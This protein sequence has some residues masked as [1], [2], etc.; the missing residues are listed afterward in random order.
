MLLHKL[1]E[2]FSMSNDKI[3]E[4]RKILRQ[5]KTMED[6]KNNLNTTDRAEDV[7]PPPVN[8]TTTEGGA[9]EP[10]PQALPDAAN[11]LQVEYD[12]L[13][14]RFEELKEQSVRKLAEYENSR[15]RLAKE[16]EEVV[17]Y[18]NEKILQDIFPVLDSLEMTLAHT[19]PAAKNPVVE[20]VELV[21]KQFKQILEKHGL[22]EIGTVGDTFDPNQHEAIGSES[23][24]EFVPG[25]ITQVHR[26]GYKLKDRLIRA[27]MVTVS[28]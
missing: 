18:S 7:Q 1:K 5:K 27:A 24:P 13:A 2:S 9:E 10:T 23:K 17:K 16:Q 4:L 6:L 21:L 25:Q 3:A 26:K 19:D 28:G 14:A 11:L 12:D 8:Q 20:G 15:K 22:T